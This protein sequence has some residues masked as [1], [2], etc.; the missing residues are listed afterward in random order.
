MLSG[1][2]RGGNPLGRIVAMSDK[3]PPRII[4]GCQ[5]KVVND[6]GRYRQL[7]SVYKRRLLTKRFRHFD[8]PEI[9]TRTPKGIPVEAFL[10]IT[11]FIVHFRLTSCN[12][13]PSQLSVMPTP[14]K[15]ET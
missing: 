15:L 2:F 12:K 6:N 1:A 13:P 4:P 10:T 5:S 7:V 14:V 11:S 3:I 9:P 8:F